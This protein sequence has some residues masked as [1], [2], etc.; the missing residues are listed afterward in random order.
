MSSL[1]RGEPLN[2][3]PGVN[4]PLTLSLFEIALQV[5]FNLS[6]DLLS[7]AAACVSGCLGRCLLPPAAVFGLCDVRKVHTPVCRLALIAARRGRPRLVV[8]KPSSLGVTLLVEASVNL[9]LQSGVGTSGYLRW[10]LPRYVS[11]AHFPIYH[12]QPPRLRVTN[13]TLTTVR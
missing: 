4:P 5:Q 8:I 12:T 6:Q 13:L 2:P 3:R 1:R 10:Y 9:G 11:H 7:A